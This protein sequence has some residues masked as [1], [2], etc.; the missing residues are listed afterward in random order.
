M[1]IASAGLFWLLVCLLPHDARAATCTEAAI[2]QAADSAARFI[3]SGYLHPPMMAIGD[4]IFNGMTS[5][6]IDAG[7]ARLSAPALVAR[8][9]G[10]SSRFREANYPRSVLFDLEAELQKGPSQLLKQFGKG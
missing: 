4:S 7:R 6:T 8:T 10:T 1:R 5:L 9:L 3:T 2:H